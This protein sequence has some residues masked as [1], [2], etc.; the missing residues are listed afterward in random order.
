MVR[1]GTSG[2][3]TPHKVRSLTARFHR[4]FSRARRDDGP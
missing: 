2:S 4:Q 3:A 1:I